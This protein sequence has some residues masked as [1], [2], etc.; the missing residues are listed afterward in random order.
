MKQT[1][2]VVLLLSSLAKADPISALSI[3]GFQGTLASG[4]Y[5]LLGPSMKTSSLGNLTNHTFIATIPKGFTGDIAWTLVIG[6]GTNA[7]SYMV[8]TTFKDGFNTLGPNVHGCTDYV[9]SAGLASACASVAFQVPFFRGS[10]PAK[11]YMDF[12]GSGTTNRDFRISAVPEPETWGLVML[13]LI[14]TSVAYWH[15]RRLRF[16]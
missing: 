9:T 10:L 1:M 5:T 7:A 13:G 3:F 2:L 12:M 4:S 8:M 16:S 6:T 11:L 15:R 14:L